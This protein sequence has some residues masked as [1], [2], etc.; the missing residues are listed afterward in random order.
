[1]RLRAHICHMQMA[2]PLKCIYMLDICHFTLEY[3]VVATN[4]LSEEFFHIV[5]HPIQTGIGL[6]LPLMYDDSLCD[7]RGFCETLSIDR[8]VC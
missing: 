5:Y 3:E 8:F 7:V 1:M 6:S 4:K 2:A